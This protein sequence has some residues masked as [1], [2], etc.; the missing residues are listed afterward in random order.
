M[1]LLSTVSTYS[2]TSP[3]ES[4]L[5]VTRAVVVVTTYNRHAQQL[6]QGSGFL[7]TNDRLVTDFHTIKGAKVIQI[8]T[9]NGE[10]IPV[11]GI[12]AMDTGADLVIL[13]LARPC[14]DTASVPVS[15]V[16]S[17]DGVLRINE[18]VSSWK[19]FTD[20]GEATWKFDQLGSSTLITAALRPG[21]KV[22]SVKAY[23][24]GTPAKQEG[25]SGPEVR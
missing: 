8:T 16:S 20:Q 14:R 5:R 1:I 4:V 7:V 2:Q 25:G 11:K 23:A 17:R 24:I 6:Q 3:Q 10:K 9:F 19:V 21:K 15:E 13:Q 12:I 22:V 18:T